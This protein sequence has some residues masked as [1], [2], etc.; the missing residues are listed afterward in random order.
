MH[1]C[2]FFCVPCLLGMAAVMAPAVAWSEA[3]APGPVPFEVFDRDGNGY[4]DEQEFNDVRSERMDARAGEGRP[5]RGAAG[6]PPFAA[7]DT[8]ADGRLTP[9]ELA[10]GQRARM[11]QQ[12]GP[13]MGPGPGMGMGM[14]MGRNMPSFADFDLDGNGIL[15]E[16][17]FNEARAQRI[18]DRASQGYPMRN[19]Q[20]APP[21][22]AIDS[23]GDGSVSPQEFSQHQEQHRRQ[24]MQ[25]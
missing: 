18:N 16:P 4:I 8:D 7:L 21:F 6:A 15:E 24:M 11:Q 1:R 22:S 12:R 19:L 10:A 9:D 17:E 3:V 25:Q 5:M 14:G 13:G 23:D 2:R 20:N